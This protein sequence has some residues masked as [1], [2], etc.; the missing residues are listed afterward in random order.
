MDSYCQSVTTGWLI[1]TITII[2]MDHSP[3]D[4][5]YYE[6]VE[7]IEDIDLEVLKDAPNIKEL[8]E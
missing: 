2:T 6:F 4:F 8:D 1:F 7:P 3:E 5:N